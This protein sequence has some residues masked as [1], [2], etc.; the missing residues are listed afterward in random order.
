MAQLLFSFFKL[1]CHNNFSLFFSR[2]IHILV[3]N[4]IS[5]YNGKILLH[6]QYLKHAHSVHFK[7]GAS[8]SL[9]PFL[10]PYNNHSEFSIFFFHYSVLNLYFNSIQWYFERRSKS[11][12]ALNLLFLFYFCVRW[13][14]TDSLG[15]Q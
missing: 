15:F 10:S 6:C 9:A 3:I 4:F 1:K 2:S 14:G 13:K 5:I 7:I 11:D 12:S 8:L